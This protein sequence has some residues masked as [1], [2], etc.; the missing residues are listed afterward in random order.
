MA[1]TREEK[2]AA[3]HVW[4]DIIKVFSK[5]ECSP[6]DALI[7]AIEAACFA[8]EFGGRDHRSIGEAI[9]IILEGFE[10]DEFWTEMFAIARQHGPKGLAQ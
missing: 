8:A 6:E 1:K 10:G 7:A 5:H 9:A 3:Q 4:L 2:I